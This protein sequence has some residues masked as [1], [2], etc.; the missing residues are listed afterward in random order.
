MKI[1]TKT[2]LALFATAFLAGC[3]S[4]QVSQ[5]YDDSINFANLKQYQW[6]PAEKQTKPTAADFKKNNPL[7][8]KRIEEDM[9][10]IMVSKGF[11]MVEQQPDAYITYHISS[12]QKV[13]SSPVTTS[14]GV[15]T[16]FGRGYGSMAFQTSPDVQ[17]YEEG[18][19]IIDI[20]STDNKLLWRGKSTTI[21]Q[22]HPS[23]EETSELV[24]EVITKLLEQYP[25]KKKN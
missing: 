6:L 15:G 19:L 5:D 17:Q 4:V 24:T 7:I 21:L 8:A 3:S 9:E 13:R 16:G 20:L 25:P 12:M 14:F 18:Q 1:L 2:A 23:H 10:K 11:V 22:E